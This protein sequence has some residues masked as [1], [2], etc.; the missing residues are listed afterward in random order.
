MRLLVVTIDTEEEGRWS[1]AYP[2]SGNTCRNIF[3][4]HHVQ[5]VFDRLGVIPTWLI[6][7]PV[8]DD[9]DAAAVLKDLA[10]PGRAEF[11]AHLHPWC[12][13]P[14]DDSAPAAGSRARTYPHNLPPE[15][16]QA[17]M[18]R[19]CERIEAGFGSRPTSYRAGRWGFDHTSVPVLE[20]AGI[21]VDT[22][23][24]PLWWDTGEGAPS[25]ASA[26][27]APYRLGRSDACR[28]GDSGV[29][30]VP[31]SGLIPAPWGGAVEAVVRRIGPAPA[32]RRTL[33]ALG[34][35][36]LRPEQYE[37]AEL[38]RLSD[39]IA[40]RGLP[41]FNLMF[42]SS[43]VLPGATPYAR[44]ASARDAFCARLEGAL[45]HILSKHGAE[46]VALSDVP[47][48]LASAR[49]GTGA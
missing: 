7:Y 26:P 11:G 8:A 2:T 10:P 25:F 24:T 37:L 12:N 38:N 46:P 3:Q 6:D 19:L 40:R 42:H 49:P 29:L 9:P 44:T 43:V 13:P 20:R 21:R 32:L 36:S 41:V 48:R 16:Q 45:E 34:Y 47:A 15:I 18:D 35:R 14:W 30:E 33:V 28:P 5:A 27:L 23:V 31:L 1:S 4:L 17:K 39:D 22:S